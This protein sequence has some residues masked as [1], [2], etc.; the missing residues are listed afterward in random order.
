MKIA[1]VILLVS[2]FTDFII[3]AGT[4][5]TTAM[6][7]TGNAA[8]PNKATILFML[9]G[10][11]VAASRTIQQALKSTPETSAALKG[12]MS[13]VSTSTVVKTP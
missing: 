7:A 4:G 6:M 5:L 13:V 12:D 9:L 2:A 8:L 10:G 3:T 1:W 11:V